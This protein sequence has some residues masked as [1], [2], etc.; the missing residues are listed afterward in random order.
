MLVCGLKKSYGLAQGRTKKVKR[1]VQ[2]HTKNGPI[3]VNVASKAMLETAV[4]DKF[5]QKQGF[6]L[7]T[8]NLDHLVK[9]DRDVGFYDAYMRQDFVVADGNPIV[10]TSRIAAQPVDLLPGSDLV[11]PMCEWARGESRSIALLGS[12]QEALE[13]SAKA[14]TD[15][16]AG[17]EVATMIAPPFGFDANSDAAAELLAQVETSGASLCFLALGAPKQ[18]LLAARGAEFAPSVGFASIGAG[19]DFYAGTQTRA[20]RWVRTI[21]MEW[22]WRLA[23]NPKRLWKRYFDSGMIMPRLVLQA[24]KDRRHDP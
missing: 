14:L 10:W 20:P 18:E 13:A 7:A 23:L 4:R 16:V 8:I 11:L 22:V 9:M 12:T 17:L 6:S 1:H 3:R 24:L 19:L 15:K 21:A 5:K 2:Y